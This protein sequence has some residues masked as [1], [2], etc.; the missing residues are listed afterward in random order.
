MAPPDLDPGPVSTTSGG[1]ARALLVQVQRRRMDTNMD[2]QVS[3]RPPR[4]RTAS[5]IRSRL[6]R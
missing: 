3:C 5:F 4:L 2:M 6:H 1:S